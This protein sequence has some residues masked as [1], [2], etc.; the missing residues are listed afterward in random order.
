MALAFPIV[1]LAMLDLFPKQRGA[2][3]SMQSFVQLVVNA[4]LAGVV[5]PLVTGSVLEL[6]LASAAFSLVGI[7]LWT[8]HL[9]AASHIH[10]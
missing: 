5:A 2:A 7:S 9:K 1:Q 4:L 10:G 3:A 8:W 6:A